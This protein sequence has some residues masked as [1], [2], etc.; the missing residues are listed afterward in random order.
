M[1]YQD[2]DDRIEAY[3]KGKIQSREQLYLIKMK[4]SDRKY[5][6]TWIREKKNNR[7]DKR[8]TSRPF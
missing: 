6:V 7:E 3:E 1:I 2:P 4:D 5:L 8:N